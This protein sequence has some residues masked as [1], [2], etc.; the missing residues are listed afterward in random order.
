MLTTDIHVQLL[1]KKLCELK[2]AVMYI[3]S[4][5]VARLPNDIVEF[6]EVGD[7]GQLWF[8]VHNPGKQVENYEQCFPVRLFFYRKGV[9][10]FVE[11]NGTATIV[12]DKEILHEKRE[13]I[14]EDCLLLKMTPSV[15]EY[16]ETGKKKLF[17]EISRF[18]SQ[19]FTSFRNLIPGREYRPAA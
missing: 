9:D 19:C 14:G 7:N 3:M 8:T 4:N 6:L 17:P 12:V 2:T 16:T 15:A 18:L 1:E 13:F 11:V 10:F 5:S